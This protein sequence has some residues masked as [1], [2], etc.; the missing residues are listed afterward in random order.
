MIDV[1][2]WTIPTVLITINEN[3]LWNYIQYDR[4]LGG[5]KMYCIQMSMRARVKRDIDF[6]DS[7][8]LIDCKPDK[9]CL[10]LLVITITTIH[11][12]HSNFQCSPIF[13]ERYIIIIW[14]FGFVCTMY[15]Q[16]LY[17]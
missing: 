4:R 17:D 12:I 14:F 6:V 9:T 16:K 3:F 2:Q 15:N 5:Y 1:T 8:S 11:S 13:F 10:I 7:E